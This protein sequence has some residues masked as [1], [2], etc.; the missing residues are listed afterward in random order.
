[1]SYKSKNVSTQ[2]S[3]LLIIAYPFPPI[4]YSGSYRLLRICKGLVTLGVRVHVL[5]INIDNRIPN[6]FDLVSQVPPSTIIHRTAI[7][8]PWMRYQSWRNRHKNMQGF[9]YINKMISLLLRLITIPDHQ[10]LWVPFAVWKG[11]KIIKHQAVNTVFTS[12]PPIS[13]H[14][15]GYWLKK[16]ANTKW[17]ADLRDPMVG[18]VFAAHSGLLSRIEGRVNFSSEKLI[19]ENADKVITTSETHRRELSEK[20]G[21]DKFVAVRNSFDMAD[22][23]NLKEGKY[24]KFT[25]SHLGSMY[26][27]RKA[28]DLFKA[29]KIVE[30]EIAPESLNLQVNFVGLNDNQ[31]EESISK[32]DVENYVKTNGLVSHKEAIEIMVRS[33]LLLLVKATGEGSYGQ[34][35]AKFFEYLGT[36]NKILCLGPKN[37]EVAKIINDLQAGY[38][39]EN[40]ETQ[41][42]SVLRKVYGDYISG[43]A[44][45][46][47]HPDLSQY[48]LE[49]MGK[50]VSE[51]IADCHGVED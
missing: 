21:L 43:T 40:N 9:R 45:E 38:V 2:D 20:Y 39:I 41:L 4:P 11:L 50:R 31:L 46:I 10:I 16:I 22:Y 3:K 32:F 47:S 33:H 25:I 29:I 37:S 36:R 24:D 14:L 34:I 26:G 23:S 7:I 17:I 6:D 5:S 30:K 48:N 15:A 12:S 51:V 8:D 13:T 19:I 18:N 28:D 44:E 27:L 49:Y 42:A 35:P 1:M